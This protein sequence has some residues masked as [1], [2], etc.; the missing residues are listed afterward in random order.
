MQDENPIGDGILPQHADVDVGCF[1]ARYHR[2][3]APSGEHLSPRRPANGQTVH[4]GML[5]S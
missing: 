3:V 1:V 2:D 4:R 5:L